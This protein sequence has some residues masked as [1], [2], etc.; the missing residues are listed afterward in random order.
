[1]DLINIL[2]NK[3]NNMEHLKEIKDLIIHSIDNRMDEINIGISKYFNDI[4]ISH[5]LN[6]EYKYNENQY[7]PIKFLIKVI[8]DNMMADDKTDL[9]HISNFIK[10]Y[11]M[12]LRLINKVYYITNKYVIRNFY[13][14]VSTNTSAMDYK[15]N[16]D[17]IELYEE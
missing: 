9:T 7:E 16:I 17:Y 13:N 4:V 2:K 3:Y 5:S 6:T 12:K 8:V 14:S 11:N 15:V 10:K 1:M